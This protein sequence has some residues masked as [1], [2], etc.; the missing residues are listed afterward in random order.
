MGWKMVAASSL[1]TTPVT[2]TPLSGAIDSEFYAVEDYVRRHQGQLLSQLRSAD[3][4]WGAGAARRLDNCI[5][6]IIGAPPTDPARRA[7]VAGLLVGLEQRSPAMSLPPSIKALFPTAIET[8]TEALRDDGRYDPDLYAKDVRFVAG[9]TAPIGALYLDIAQRQGF[10]DAARRAL[11]A[12]AMV[13]RLLR[14]GDLTGA[15]TLVQ[16][17]GWRPWLEIHTDPRRFDEF[18]AAGWDACYRR[19]ADFLQTRDEAAGLW[20]ASWFYDPKVSEISPRL[21][22]L[23]AGPSANGA[24][25]I[26]IG[27]GAIHTERAGEAS[28]TR[29]AL[30]EAG[31]YR[32]ICYAMFWPRHDLLAWASKPT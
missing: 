23:R 22:Y 31:R 29:R 4:R 12:C 28:P 8:L 21:A 19:I 24:V 14:M 2:A 25:F 26:R 30:I 27:P 11:H 18:N 3:D 17:R 13:L 10:G 20:G 16:A 1:I 6:K 15:L 7:A 5:R 32:P 9:L